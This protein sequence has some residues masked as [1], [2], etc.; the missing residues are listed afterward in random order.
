[1]DVLTQEI[2]LE[3]SSIK[4]FIRREDLIHPFVSGNK[5]RKLK[6]NLE[7][8]QKEKHCSLLTFG[9]AF[10]NHIAATAFAGKKIGFETIGVIRGEE[11]ASKIQENPTL[12]FAKECGMKFEFVSREKYKTK[13]SKEF[14]SELAQKFGSFYLIPE[15]GTNDLAVKGCEEI[16]T[17]RDS[18]YDFI[19]CSIGTGGTIAG[20]INRS[21]SHQKVLGFPSLKGDF[22]KEDICKF[23]TNTNWDINSKYH[24]GG[25]AKVS[26]ELIF[27]MN[28][29]YSKYKILL[30]P[31]YT[32]KLV[33]G[34]IDLISK[35]YFPLHSKILIIH[36]GGVQGIAGMNLKLKSKNLQTI[37]NND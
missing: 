30:D 29:F 23:V 26:D 19:C 33:F 34:V 17:D 3:N 21:F 15:G 35:N 16:L 37:L 27:F 24:F 18:D 5:F 10:S 6:Y 2:P 12:K 4:L 25:Y 36:T 14:I 20:L 7:Q 31:I 9:G 28:N 8:A 13:D 32:G 1:M 22:L 11:L